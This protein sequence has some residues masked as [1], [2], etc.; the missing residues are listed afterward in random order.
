MKKCTTGIFTKE[1]HLSLKIT[2]YAL[3]QL[4]S[5]CVTELGMSY[6]LLVKFQTDALEAQFDQYRQI[7]GS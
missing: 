4:T 5:Y 3:F 2:T 6:V 1:T 7:A